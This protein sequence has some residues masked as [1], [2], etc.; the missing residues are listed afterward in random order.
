MQSTGCWNFLL[1]GRDQKC[2]LVALGIILCMYALMSLHCLSGLSV[3]LDAEMA[4]DDIEH[5]DSYEDEAYDKDDDGCWGQSDVLRRRL[6]GAG[7]GGWVWRFRVCCGRHG[8]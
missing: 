6:S 3:V 7:H 2:C 4:V 5:H 1:G 8:G